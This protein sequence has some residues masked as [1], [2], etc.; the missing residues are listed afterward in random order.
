MGGESRQPHPG[1]HCHRCGCSLPGLT[2]FTVSCC[3]GT[4]GPHHCVA[5][6][7]L[8]RRSSAP[9]QSHPEVNNHGGS[10]DRPTAPE[11]HV[12]YREFR[13]K[14]ITRH[15][16]KSMT[17]RPLDTLFLALWLSLLALPQ[18]GVAQD[19]SPAILE[20]PT[21][22]DEAALSEQA[23]ELWRR[24]AEQAGSLLERSRDTAGAWWSSSRDAWNS[25]RDAMTPSEPDSFGQVWTE[26][27]PKLEQTVELTELQR[28]LPE[29]A[30][31]QRDQADV[32]EDINAL[33]DAAV[34]IL[35]TSPVQQ[36]RDRIQA[37]EQQIADARTEI[38][39]FRRARVAAPEKSLVERTLSDY[40]KLIDERER[41][42]E[43]AKQELGAIKRA[44]AA[45]LR[46]MGLDLSDE[47]LEFLLST[48]VG[49]N[50]V[51]LGVVFENV[52]AIT[53]QLEAL[54]R[55]SGED[56]DSARR[57]YGMYLVLLRALNEMHLDVE[58]AIDQ[59][60]VPRIKAIADRAEALSQETRQLKRENPDKA[61]IL[62][63][64][65]Q[66]QRLTVE[67]AGV[68]RDYLKQQGRQV[69]T[70]R[71]SLQSDIAAARNTYETVRV[72][73]ELVDLIQSSQQLLDGLLSR[74][75]PALRPF[76]NLEMQRELSKL[77]EQLR[78]ADG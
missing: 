64:N 35:S 23:A 40:D 43:R 2:G 57:Y 22:A 21:V 59:R 44:F 70:A 62:D 38:G 25:A 6:S 46:A 26:V 24:S 41:S 16:S 60:Y 1:T 39:S 34:E 68:Y 78:A 13:R 66:A 63:A 30:W 65:L 69:A 49:D 58:Q 77:T 42:I 8:A 45:E 52:K 53:A 32:E 20:P 18:V 47:Q 14:P 3:G 76:Q 61:E 54:M 15:I 29:S 74:Q 7:G 12:E 55:D 9:Y 17:H 28:D 37:L 27:V 31:F 36:Y 75:V 10:T 4:D 72:S 48:V 11:G 67:A 73:G 5:R 19:A 33:L 50:L 56:L 51:D 71:R